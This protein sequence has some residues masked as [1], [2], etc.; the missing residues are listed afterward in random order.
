MTPAAFQSAFAQDLKDFI[1]H[2]RAI[3]YRYAT[4]AAILS[5]FDG[6]CSRYHGAEQLLSKELVT[7]W[8]ERR[9]GESIGTLRIRLVPVRQ[10]A[11]YLHQLDREAY[12]IP[13]RFLPPYR[14]YFPYIFTAKELAAFFARTDSCRRSARHPGR[15][16]LMPVLFRLLYCC[17][18]RVSEA[19]KL[20]VKHVDLPTGVLTVYGG[21]FG[22][23][24]RVPMSEEMASRC[25]AYATRVHAFADSDSY[26]FSSSS[27][28]PRPLNVKTVYAN[29]RKFLWDARIS[30][31][32]VGK[33][34]RLHDLR[35][36]FAVHCLSRWVEEGKDLSAYLPLLKTYL[37]HTHFRETAYYLRL[38]PEVYPTITAQVE[39]VFAPVIPAIEAAHEND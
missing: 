19:T 17:G 18:L 21:K 16:L 24:R 39:Q 23:D 3:G 5:R 9:A 7:H 8:A 4:E 38:T 33:G 12:V 10:F 34:P 25:R 35:H 32:G 14:R 2:K 26:F 36:T 20:K 11:L 22:K 29:F 30:H 37:G 15:H 1:T 28:S 27:S 13:H 6:F 31:G